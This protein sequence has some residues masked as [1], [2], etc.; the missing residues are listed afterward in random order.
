MAIIM[1]F[2]LVN[3]VIVTNTRQER[4]SWLFATILVVTMVL[5]IVP[6]AH[7]SQTT[8][9]AMSVLGNIVLSLGAFAAVAAAALASVRNANSDDGA[10]SPRENG[11][12]GEEERDENGDNNKDDDGIH[13]NEDEQEG[14]AN[15]ANVD[16][17]VRRAEKPKKKTFSVLSLNV[18]GWGRKKVAD[19]MRSENGEPGG[20]DLVVLCETRL[21]DGEE[22][23]VPKNYDAV[24]NEWSERELHEQWRDDQIAKIRAS[25]KS[26]VE[27]EHAIDELDPNGRTRSGGELVLV[28]NRWKAF[29][30]SVRKSDDK[31]AVW[32]TFRFNANEE[33]TFACV[34]A[35]AG[36]A[37]EKRAF[38]RSLSESVAPL[39]AKRIVIV[40]DFNTYQ[41]RDLDAMHV[42][43]SR[44]AERNDDDHDG[45]NDGDGDSDRE[46]VPQRENERREDRRRAATRS[47]WRIGEYVDLLQHVHDVWRE[48]NPETREYTWEWISG[49]TG[50]KRASRIDAMLVSEAARS[51]VESADILQ[52]SELVQTDHRP[53]Q[54]RLSLAR[55]RVK[56][57]ETEPLPKNMVK[58]AKAIGQDGLDHVGVRA[59][60]VNGLR[61]ELGV[62]VPDRGDRPALDVGQR[63]AAGA[64]EGDRARMRLHDPPERLAGQLAQRTG[65]SSRRS[66]PRSAA[67]PR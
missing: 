10:H 13:D 20:H 66:R 42:A 37:P 57:I 43:G 48:R 7:A 33:W 65:R 58:Q 44:E 49:E 8:D 2:E 31:R 67:H 15:E 39:L 47:A 45:T 62:P 18:R 6:G 54:L 11:T 19:V 35:P 17:G 16:G 36:R 28:H 34:Y 55:L 32:L 41:N 61:T 1:F 60:Q 12:N 50:Q 64:R 9:A 26:D 52:R 4:R 53:I 3:C 24:R 5:G 38:W 29:L 27:K 63:L 51:Y 14:D 22:L 59:D 56:E 23:D 46:D 30:K 40:G 21:V 25:D